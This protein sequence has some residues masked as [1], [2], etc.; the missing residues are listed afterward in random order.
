MG[1]LITFL[2]GLF[3]ILGALI[4]FVSKND[5]SFINFSIGLAFSVIIMLIIFDLSKEVYEIFTE[6]YS[7]TISII[8][9]MLTIAIGIIILKVLEEFIPHHHHECDNNDCHE[10]L[11]HIG[12]ISSIALVLHN[13]VEGMAVYNAA[14]LSAERGALL[15]IGIGLHNVPLGMIITASLYVNN[16]NKKRTF[17]IVTLIALST[18]IGGIIMTLIGHNIN[19][20]IEGIILGITLGMLIYIS[21]IELLPKVLKEKRTI[22]TISGLLLGI[23]VIALALAF[24]F[25]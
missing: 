11:T 23:A 20:T 21:I 14:E 2:L 7:Y 3:I 25:H 1:L 13:I 15:A 24:S 17:V 12:L 4:V 22:P 19:E 5:K 8:A 6:N 9:I 10:N 16:K 18:F